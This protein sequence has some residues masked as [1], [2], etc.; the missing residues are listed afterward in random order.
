MNTG[1]YTEFSGKFCQID[2]YVLS[3]MFKKL[4]IF[5]DSDVLK[6]KRYSTLQGLNGGCNIFVV[7]H[8]QT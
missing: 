2:L 7:L 8:E 5:C 3:K 1:K 4:Y 6:N